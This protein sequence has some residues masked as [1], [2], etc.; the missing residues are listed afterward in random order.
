LTGYSI[1]THDK[2]V[3]FED[4][5]DLREG[6]QAGLNGSPCRA[7]A[8]ANNLINRLK[9]RTPEVVLMDTNARHFRH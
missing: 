3:L 2:V 6:I 7:F 9:E 5:K 4:N 1:K 8:N